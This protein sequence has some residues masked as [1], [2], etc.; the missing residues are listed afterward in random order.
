MTGAIDLQDTSGSAADVQSLLAGIVPREAVQQGRIAMAMPA[1]GYACGN[2]RLGQTVFDCSTL[3]AHVVVVVR[4]GGVVLRMADGTCIHLPPGAAAV[5]PKGLEF[6][7]SSEAGSEFAFVLLRS[8]TRTGS[9]SSA[10]RLDPD[11]ILEPTA[12]PARELIT[13]LPLPQ[14]RRNVLFREA[15]GRMLVGVWDATPYTRIA[16]GFAQHELM[17]IV[18]GSVRL[19]DSSGK[20]VV[21]RAGDTFLMP[22]DTPTAWQSEGTVKKIFCHFFP[23]VSHG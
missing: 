23:E 7:W 4:R 14:V 16:A 6:Q 22:R 15:S 5:L 11:V 9:I 19:T 17:H 21:F 10:I 8:N 2:A 13:S 3:P 1:H 20:A 12:G 18:E